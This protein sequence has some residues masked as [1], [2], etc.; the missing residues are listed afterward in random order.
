M[1]EKRKRG[2]PRTTEKAGLQTGDTRGSFVVSKQLWNELRD[3][4]NTS[5]YRSMRELMQVMIEAWLRDHRE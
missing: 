1:T 2:R 4:Q 3:W 5:K